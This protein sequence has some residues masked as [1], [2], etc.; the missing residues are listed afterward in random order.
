M[1]KFL[2]VFL[3]CLL[4]LQF[5]HAAVSAYAEQVVE[6]GAHHHHD[7]DSQAGEQL[8]DGSTEPQDGDND[9]AGCEACHH[10]CCGFMDFSSAGVTA[11]KHSERVSAASPVCAPQHDP[12]PSYRPPIVSPA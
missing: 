12:E 5:S 6:E 11:R 7:H 8:P 4:P 3:L 2:L 10:H 9:C 1:R